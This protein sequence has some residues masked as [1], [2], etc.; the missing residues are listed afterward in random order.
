[1]KIKA[2][3]L[4]T[5]KKAK[6]ENERGKC[7]EIKGKASLPCRRSKE[8]VIGQRGRLRQSAMLN[9]GQCN[10]LQISSTLGF[11]RAAEIRWALYFNNGL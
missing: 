1:V 7:E 5:K 11:L 8:G 6:I 10:M 9:G 2:K 3:P 4:I